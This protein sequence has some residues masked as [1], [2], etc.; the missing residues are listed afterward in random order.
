[1]WLWLLLS[2]LLHYLLTVPCREQLPAQGPEPCHMSSWHLFCS[3]C[4]VVPA[5]PARLHMRIRLLEPNTDRLSVPCRLLLQSAVSPDTMSSRDLWLETG[6]DEPVRCLCGVPCRLLVPPWHWLPDCDLSLPSRTLLPC[7]DWLCHPIPLRW[8]KVQRRL[9]CPGQ[10]AVQE[11]YSRI[12]LPC[13]QPAPQPSLP[14]RT[15]LPRR[16]CRLPHHSLPR[17]NVHWHCAGPHCIDAV[18]A[19]YLWKL[20][21]RREC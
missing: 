13:R 11:L 15:L 6:W 2:W 16:D 7:R 18:S 17:W 5:L 1:M 12:V 19:L 8:R 4:Y 10:L 9:G 14:Q 21:P 20:L 3:R